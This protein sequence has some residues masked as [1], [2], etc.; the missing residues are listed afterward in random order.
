MPPDFI[1]LAAS[2]ASAA[3]LIRG[4][5]TLRTLP[6]SAQTAGTAVSLLPPQNAAGNN[7]SLS[8]QAEY[9][10]ALSSLEA[11]RRVRQENVGRF[12]LEEISEGQQFIL[13]NLR[14]N[15]L[16]GPARVVQETV[17]PVVANESIVGTA[18]LPLQETA[19]L[20]PQ[21]NTSL[22]DTM[23]RAA[24][25]ISSE[26]SAMLQWDMSTADSRAAWYEGRKEARARRKAEAEAAE[27]GET[28]PPV[29]NPGPAMLLN[30]A[31]LAAR[32]ARQQRQAA[33]ILTSLSVNV[34]QT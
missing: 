30:L 32:H 21:N 23:S 26:E 1:S 2:R 4:R 31:G 27:R 24:D 3:D 12:Q 34:A 15:A 5:G 13:Q 25:T 22:V 14:R 29:V 8:L 16:E 6:A 20:P 11:L 7:P 18:T 28:L 9:N 10:R 17:V 33:G 19:A